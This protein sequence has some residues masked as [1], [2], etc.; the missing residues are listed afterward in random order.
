MV[1]QNYGKRSGVIV[2][3]CGD[4]GVWFDA[5]ELFGV[6]KWVRDAGLARS[7]LR[8]EELKREAERERRQRA[9]TATVPGVATRRMREDTSGVNFFGGLLSLLVE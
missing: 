1:R 8:D 6:L 7:K 4:H 9:S 5:D 3:H 2:D